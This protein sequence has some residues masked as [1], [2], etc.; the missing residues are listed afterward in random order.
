MNAHPW[1]TGTGLRPHAQVN[2]ICFGS[3]GSGGSQFLPWNRL[4]PDWLRVLGVQLPGR[5]FR[6]RE[7]LCY[8]LDELTHAIAVAQRG[9]SG[10]IAFF[11]HSFGAL[12]AFETA[13]RL[14]NLGDKE[15]AWMVVA[16]RASPHL[17]LAYP[18]VDRL[19]E[20][21]FLDVVHRFGGTDPQLLENASSL[22]AYLPAI[23]A[24]LRINAE[25]EYTPGPPL[26][27]PVAAMRGLQDPVCSR[28]ELQAWSA[29]TTVPLQ[30]H[31]WDGAH[32]FYKDHLPRLFS[33][34]TNLAG[35]RS[36]SADAPIDIMEEAGI[37]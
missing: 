33:I 5:E 6:H 19:P 13:R 8:D 35:H 25:Y 14:R 31:E 3:A 17:A 28:Q 4:A 23:R 27:I 22:R 18:K 10:P 7:P 36:A 29:T 9:L 16:G 20:T 15:P 32:F 24:D 1:F 34:F 37:A 26:T 12:L 2:L 21:E 30:M 11:G